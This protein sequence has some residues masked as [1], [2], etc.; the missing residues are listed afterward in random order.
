MRN[1]FKSILCFTAK[2]LALAMGVLLLDMPLQ[3][4]I[5]V[6]SGHDATNNVNTNW[7]DANNWTGGKPGPG[8]NIFFFDPGANV[9]QGVVDN[10]VDGN[11]TILSLQ[12]GNTNGFHTTQIDSGITLTISNTAAATLLFVGTG[13]DNGGSQMV[14]A[15][16]TGL[17]GHL[18]VAGTNSASSIIIQQGSSTSSTHNA[19]LNLAGLDTFNLTA[20]CWSAEILDQ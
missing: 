20:G 4:Q 13:T 3:A 2:I 1:R 10:I 9:T 11:T 7:S 16:V 12:Y 6:W 14:D 8:T 17:G 15:T 18:V 19:T 5:V